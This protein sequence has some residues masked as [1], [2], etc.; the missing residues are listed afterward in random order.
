MATSMLH[1]HLRKYVD[2]GIQQKV[3][4]SNLQKD[5]MEQ[6]KKTRERIIDQ[7]QL[8]NSMKDSN[9]GSEK[10]Q[11]AESRLEKDKKLLKNVQSY[12]E[13]AEKEMADLAIDLSTHMEELSS[14]E[15]GAGGF[16]VHSIG[17]DR[18]AKLDKTNMVVTFKPSGHVEIPIG[19]RIN[20]W[21]DSSQLTIEKIKKA[22]N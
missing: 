7:T 14:I 21:K 8:V 1:A 20:S 19:A 4:L 15:I 17:V 5:Y 10:I 18:N 11:V 6:E 13:E 22:G 16:V 2:D 9:L 12:M 3:R